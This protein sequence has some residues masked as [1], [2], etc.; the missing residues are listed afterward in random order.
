[1]FLYG[2]QKSG[3]SWLSNNLG[4]APEIFDAGLKEWRFWRQYFATVEDKERSIRRLKCRF[5]SGQNPKR[6]KMR[7]EMQLAP[8]VFLRKSTEHVVKSKHQHILADFTPGTGMNLTQYQLSELAGIMAALGLQT[9]ALYLLR[10]PLERAVSQLSM[11][12]FNGRRLAFNVP[13]QPGTIEYATKIDELVDIHIDQITIRS[14]AN[15]I[16]EKAMAMESTIPFQVILFDNLF[17]QDALNRVSD[18]LSI[19]SVTFQS[20]VIGSHSKVELSEDNTLTI[21]KSLLPTYQYLKNYFGDVGFPAS[22]SKSLSYLDGQ[23]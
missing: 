9:K 7:Y 3:T 19:E 15:L 14:R 17:S 16:I 12:V 23:L 21:A 6:M 10:D 13:F 1:M 2:A 20:E 4:A 11:H 22:W 18:F 8:D 5:Q